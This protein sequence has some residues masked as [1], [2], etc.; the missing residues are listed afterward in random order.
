MPHVRQFIP[1]IDGPKINDDQRIRI[2]SSAVIIWYVP[3]FRSAG[4][5]SV[6]HYEVLRSYWN[7]QYFTGRASGKPDR[8]CFPR[9]GLYCCTISL[10]VVGQLYQDMFSP[11]RYYFGQY[12]S[13]CGLKILFSL[14]MMQLARIFMKSIWKTEHATRC[15]SL[16]FLLS[17]SCW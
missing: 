11:C 14:L 10:A 15:Y 2:Y 8:D 1:Q 5:N 6:L 17:T 13:I 9:L 12:C 16:T 4:L 7:R 3:A